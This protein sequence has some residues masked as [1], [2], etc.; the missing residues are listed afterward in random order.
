MPAR[1]KTTKTAAR[2]ASTPEKVECAIAVPAQADQPVSLTPE[3]DQ[4]IDQ[5]TELV[6]ADLLHAEIQ[7]RLPATLAR[8]MGDE[9]W[10]NAQMQRYRPLLAAATAARSMRGARGADDQ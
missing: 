3:V 9:T 5:L 8:L 2:S 6:A 1:K 7:R 10:L 4:R